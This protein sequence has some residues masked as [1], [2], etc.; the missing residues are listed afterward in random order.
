MDVN[1]SHSTAQIQDNEMNNTKSLITILTPYP[2]V[3][4]YQI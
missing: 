1:I 2:S 4:Q 3:T